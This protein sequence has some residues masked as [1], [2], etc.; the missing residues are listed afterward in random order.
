MIKGHT[1]RGDNQDREWRMECRTLRADGDTTYSWVTWPGWSED[2]RAQA[3]PQGE[4]DALHAYGVNGEGVRTG[5][6][7]CVSLCQTA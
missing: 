2:A 3:T 7:R 6:R 1:S 4:L 5:M